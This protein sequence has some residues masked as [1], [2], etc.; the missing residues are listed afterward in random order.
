MSDHQTQLRAAVE[1]ALD[2]QDLRQNGT[3]YQDTMTEAVMQAVGDGDGVVENFLGLIE[4][5]DP[6]RAEIKALEQ[7]IANSERGTW[8]ILRK[9]YS[10]NGYVSCYRP[11]MAA[12]DGQLSAHSDDL[13]DAPPTFQ[14]I[15]ARMVG[16]E[17]YLL[18]K[19]IERARWS[20]ENEAAAERMKVRPGMVFKNVTLNYRKWST[21]IVEAADAGSVTLSGTKRG[22]KNR[23]SVTV[24]AA[25]LEE[26]A[27]ASGWTAP[28]DI[29]NAWGA[30]A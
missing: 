30:A 1:A 4:L 25:Y 26:A 8:A 13:Y 11:I 12:G 9:Q 24:A 29:R 6:T 3:L 21:L 19:E 10:G 23:W 18:R 2:N 20:A 28:P 5:R 14:R 22:S 27:R 15:R 17:I 16:Y 7:R